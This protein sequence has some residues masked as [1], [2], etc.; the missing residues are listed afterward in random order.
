MKKK[1]VEAGRWARGGRPLGSL[2][3]APRST[4]TPSALGRS[5]TPT[6]A[7]AET[8][9]WPAP[10]ERAL[11]SLAMTDY[12]VRIS[13]LTRLI[14]RMQHE[15]RELQLKQA[16]QP[17]PKKPRLNDCED[18]PFIRHDSALHDKRCAGLLESFYKETPSLRPFQQWALRQLFVDRADVLCVQP[19]GSGKSR[20]FEMASLLAMPIFF[21]PHLP[22]V[23]CLF[24]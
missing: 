21:R 24:S 9:R 6:P 19:T 12:T 8:S 23:C 13:I 16:A 18:L 4:R 2:S 17:P 11:R 22:G 3:P 1:Q 20:I 14:A 10:V 5:R 15:I 7:V